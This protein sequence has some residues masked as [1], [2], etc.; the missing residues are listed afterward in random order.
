MWWGIAAIGAIVGLLSFTRYNRR[1][2]DPEI[3]GRMVEN[4]RERRERQAKAW[5]KAKADYKK[6]MEGES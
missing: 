2:N 6:K 3:W 4:S 1:I 5:E